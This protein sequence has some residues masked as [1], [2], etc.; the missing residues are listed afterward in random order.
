VKLNLDHIWLLKGNHDFIDD[1]CPYLRWVNNLDRVK[2]IVSPEMIS[3]HDRNFLF[4]P[5]TKD[6][7]QWNLIDINRADYIFCHQTFNGAISENGSKLSGLSQVYFANSKARVYSGD[8][9]KNQRVDR[10]TYI[11]APYLINFGDSFYPRCIV[12]DPISGQEEDLHFQTTTRMTL[13]LQSYKQ[14]ESYKFT[15]KT[16]LKVRLNLPPSELLDWEKHKREVIRICAERGVELYDVILSKPNVIE[17]QIKEQDAAL[18]NLTPSQ[19]FAKY[20]EAYKIERRFV[21]YGKE[22]LNAT[23]KT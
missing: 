16:Q 6:P 18:K 17:A 20:C 9:H 19:L 22:L 12:L 10:V 7:S 3:Y 1:T 21:N 11:G 14:L 5:S 8:I 13:D 4:L 23:Q 15:D 2:F